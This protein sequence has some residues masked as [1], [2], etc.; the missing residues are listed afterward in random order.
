MKIDWNSMPIHSRQ[1]S[2]PN[3]W[4]IFMDDINA[5][6]SALF[7]GKP[8]DAPFC[9]ILTPQGKSRWVVRFG[10]S[11]KPGK[12][13]T[14]FPNSFTHN[15]K[16]WNIENLVDCVEVANHLKKLISDEESLNLLRNDFKKY[17]N[18]RDER[19]EAGQEKVKANK[20]YVAQQHG[21]S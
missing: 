2:G 10:Y 16:G 5:T 15:K 6:I 8:Y 11:T 17:E 19:A 7:V 9:K 3:R 13:N 14:W 12:V 1:K 4:H 21:F 18:W 20:E